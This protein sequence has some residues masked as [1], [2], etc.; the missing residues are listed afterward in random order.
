[1]HSMRGREIGLRLDFCALDDRVEPWCARVRG[2]INDMQ[3]G[4]P[5]ARHDQVFALHGRVAMARRA[6]VPAH[7]VQLV[8]DTW[9]FEA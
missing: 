1:M 4:R 5:H 7:V 3:I 8:S 9:H 2:T 6:G